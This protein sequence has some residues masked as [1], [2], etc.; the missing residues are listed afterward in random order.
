MDDTIAMLNAQN[1]A[2]SNR[3]PVSSGTR[4]PGQ[5]DTVNISIISRD[6][7]I[8]DDVIDERPVSLTLYFISIV[9]GNKNYAGICL[10]MFIFSYTFCISS[11]ESK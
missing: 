8:N 5:D 11:D 10:H 9:S 1:K 2:T 4:E 6:E 7:S 3:E